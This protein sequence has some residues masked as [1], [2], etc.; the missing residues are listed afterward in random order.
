MNFLPGYSFQK[1]NISIRG[2]HTN[3]FIWIPAKSRMRNHEADKQRFQ[4]KK[5]I[6]YKGHYMIGITQ[7]PL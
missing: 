4:N 2:D 7:G 3:G 5:R 1:K 6:N